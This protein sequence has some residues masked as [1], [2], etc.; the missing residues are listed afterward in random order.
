MEM[1]GDIGT[2]CTLSRTLPDFRHPAGNI[3]TRARGM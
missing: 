1:R 2:A 3:L